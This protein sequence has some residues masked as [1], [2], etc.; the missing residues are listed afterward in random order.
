MQL[1]A[2]SP[3][4][5]EG[6]EHLYFYTLEE[7]TGRT[8]VHGETVGTGIY[9]LTHFQNNEEAIVE[10]EMDAMGLLFRP[11]EYGVTLDEFINTV[12]GMKRYSQEAKSLFSI[13]NTID[14]TRD[15][16][17]RLWKKLS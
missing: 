2:K 11:K 6:S 3:R 17:E 1:A 4:P 5:E 14:I 13:V 7:Q 9:V 8:F 16:A 10:R 15:D 12:L